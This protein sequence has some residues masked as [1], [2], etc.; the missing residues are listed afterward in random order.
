MLVIPKQGERLSTL[1]V[2]IDSDARQLVRSML[3]QMECWFFI[4]EAQNAQEGFC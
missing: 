4:V 3:E 1:V 2:D